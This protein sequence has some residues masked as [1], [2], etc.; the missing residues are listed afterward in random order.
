[1]KNMALAL[2]GALSP[3]AL[4]AENENRGQDGAGLVTNQTGCWTPANVVY[5]VKSNSVNYLAD[6]FHDV[7]NNFRG[8]S[9]DLLDNPRWLQNKMPYTGELLMGHL[10]YGTHGANTIETVHPFLRQNNW[11]SR[12]LVWAIL[13]WPMWRTVQQLVSFGQYLKKIRYRHDPRK[14][15]TLPGWWSTAIV[16]GNPMDIP[17][18]K[19]TIYLRQLDIQRL[20]K[21][22]CKNL[23]ADM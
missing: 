9:P 5:P 20:L 17:M 16:F 18:K 6:L 10:R 14:N 8:L 1:M 15:G 3:P 19:S 4:N 11:I 23:M 2:Y 22:A 21:R 7:F 12:N 13:I